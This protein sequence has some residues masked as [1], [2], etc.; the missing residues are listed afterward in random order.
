VQNVYCHDVNGDNR[1]DM[2]AAEGFKHP[3]G[4]IMWAEAPAAPKTELWTVHVV[5]QDLDGPENIWAGGLDRHP[6][7]CSKPPIPEN[8]QNAL[9]MSFSSPAVEIGCLVLTDF[10]AAA[11][12]T[13]TPLHALAKCVYHVQRFSTLEAACDRRETGMIDHSQLAPKILRETRHEVVVIKPAGVA[14]QLTSDPRGVSLISWLQRAYPPPIEPKLPHRLDRVTRGVMLVA[15]TPEAIAFH[16]AQIRSKK[17][18]KYY[19]ARVHE[20]RDTKI[21]ALLGQHKAYLKRVRGRARVVR[22]GGKPSFLEI[23]AAHPAPGRRGQ[24]HLFVKLLTGRF[25]QVRVML[26]ALGVPLVGDWLYGQ[27]RSQQQSRER[28]GHRSGTD[29]YLEHV[30]L[31]YVDYEQR[32]SRVAHLPD[33]DDREAID[34]AIQRAIDVHLT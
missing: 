34:S 32:A 1:L 13:M 4:R 9:E 10:A 12:L 3:D 29:F 5:A 20:P 33:D 17:W 6:I 14:S 30:L 27:D 18:E 22:S 19:L 31:K 2:V 25:H 21:E 24:T 7:S 26:A 15:L 11:H 28:Q 23:L 16:N 8:G